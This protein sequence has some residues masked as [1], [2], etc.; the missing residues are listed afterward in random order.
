MGGDQLLDF[1][2]QNFESLVDKF[3]DIKSVRSLWEE[4]VYNEYEDSFGDAP[5]TEDR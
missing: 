5:D 4:F 3:L 1:E 2:A